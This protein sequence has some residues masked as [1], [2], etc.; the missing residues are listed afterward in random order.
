MLVTDRADIPGIAQYLNVFV[1]MDPAK[2]KVCTDRHGIHFGF[3][4]F[5]RRGSVSRACESDASNQRSAVNKTS[6]LY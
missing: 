2:L 1:V 3:G 5:S 4:A 6:M